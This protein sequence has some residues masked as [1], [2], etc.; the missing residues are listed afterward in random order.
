MRPHPV[1]ALVQPCRSA[2]FTQRKAQ[3]HPN[4][5][6]QDLHPFLPPAV[7][8]LTRSPPLHRPPCS[9]LNLPVVLSPQ[10]FARAVCYAWDTLN[11][12]PSREY[13]HLLTSVMKCHLLKEKSAHSL[14]HGLWPPP[15][16]VFLVLIYLLLIRWYESPSNKRCSLLIGFVYSL[17][18]ASLPFNM[19]FVKTGILSRL[20]HWCVPDTSVCVI[21]Y[22]PKNYLLNEWMDAMLREA[23]KTTR[24]MLFR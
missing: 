18:S 20:V 7:F 16:L 6:P 17:M 1:T 14:N 22:F 23:S 13:L 24:Y 10:V 2:R 8:P 5:A 3:V 19:S 21:K 12:C 9:F 15:L 11:G 4:K